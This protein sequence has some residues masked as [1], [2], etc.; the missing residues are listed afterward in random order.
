MT[1]TLTEQKVLKKLG[2]SSMY[3]GRWFIEAPA[4]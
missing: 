4:Q 2:I 1:R 3:V